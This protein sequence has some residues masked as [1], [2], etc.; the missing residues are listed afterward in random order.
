MESTILLEE[1]ERRHPIVQHASSLRFPDEATARCQAGAQGVSERLHGTWIHRPA[2]WRW[3]PREERITLR[4]SLQNRRTTKRPPGKY[5]RPPAQSTC[6]NRTQSASGNTP[7][8]LP[9]DCARA[10]RVRGS[11]RLNPT[12][13]CTRTVVQLEKVLVLHA[14]KSWHGGQRLWFR[15]FRPARGRTA[16]HMRKPQGIPG[17]SLLRLRRIRIPRPPLVHCCV[18]RCQMRSGCADVFFANQRYSG[19]K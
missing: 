19:C 10:G 13:D 17:N 11:M 5:P 14:N 3:Q 18:H 15:S 12:R 9:G 16:E 2:T 4:T 6:K 1:P 7:C 8:F